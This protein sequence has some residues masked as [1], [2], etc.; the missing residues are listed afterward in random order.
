MTESEGCV[1]LCYVRKK[2]SL[3]FYMCE[4][5]FG[6]VI[7]TRSKDVFPNMYLACRAT[8][9]ELTELIDNVIFEIDNSEFKMGF[10]YNHTW[11]KNHYADGLS[12]SCRTISP[13]IL[14][15][16][17][18]YIFSNSF[19]GTDLLEKYLPLLVEKSYSTLLIMFY[20]LPVYTPKP[21]EYIL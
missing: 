19:I 8:N 6:E 10:W 14:D 18:D 3:K 4:N 13:I 17:G 2:N 20:N 12:N 15:I 5:R 11:R 7:V 9:P 1:L 21:A 16:R